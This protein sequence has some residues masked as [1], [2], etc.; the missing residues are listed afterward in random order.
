[1]CQLESLTYGKRLAAY[2][3]SLTP[4]STKQLNSQFNRRSQLKHRRDDIETGATQIHVRSFHQR[5]NSL[6]MVGLIDRFGLSRNPWTLR[7]PFS[8]FQSPARFGTFQICDF[9]VT[10]SRGA[11]KLLRFAF[12]KSLIPNSVP[13]TFSGMFQHGIGRDGAT[14]KTL[15]TGGGASVPPTLCEPSG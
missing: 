5:E 4:I 8:A 2:P 10:N 6:S 15:E 13:K 7:K 1:V 14:P 11:K 3:L 12:R 9:L